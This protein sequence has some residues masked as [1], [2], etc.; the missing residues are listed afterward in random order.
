MWRNGCF[1]LG[2]LSFMVIGKL[3]RGGFAEDLLMMIRYCVPVL[4]Q[5][6]LVWTIFEILCKCF[7]T[8]VCIRTNRLQVYF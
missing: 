5:I 4:W 8:D 1:G 2:L 3:C 7:P 6:T